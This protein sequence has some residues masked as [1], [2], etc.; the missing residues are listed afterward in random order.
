MYYIITMVNKEISIII[1]ARNEENY[2]PKTLDSLVSQ[3]GISRM[4]IIVSVSPDT[5][6]N[7]S[8]IAKDYGCKLAE[9]GRTTTAKNNGAKEAK[10]DTLFFVDADTYP[11][12]DHFFS[13]LLDEFYSRNLDVAGCL[14][15]P[16]FNGSK[17]KSFIYKKAFDF[18]NKRFLSREK[19]LNPRKA[20]GN[21]FRKNAFFDLGGFKEGIFAEDFEMVKRAVLPPHSFNF[22]IL[23]DCGNLKTSV[24]R[25]EREGKYKEVG[26][27]FRT[28]LMGLYY[29]AKAEIFGYDSIQGSADSYFGKAT[30][31]YQFA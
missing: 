6:D 24:R 26:G 7:T 14:L 18:V 25:Y 12:N 16:D 28:T 10:F 22:G 2:L 15:S 4:E 8:F 1:P 20:T 30:R 3:K 9:G 11:K 13:I 21:V 23:K 17:F 5:Y 19:T 29:I 27:L 31:E